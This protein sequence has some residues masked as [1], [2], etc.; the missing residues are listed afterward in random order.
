VLAPLLGRITSESALYVGLVPLGLALVAVVV[1]VRNRD[2]AARFWAWTTAGALLLFLGAPEMI[3]G[4]DQPFL[5]VRDWTFV[6][7]LVVLSLALLGGVALD[8]V[9]SGLSTRWSWGIAIALVTLTVLDLSGF[10]SRQHSRVAFPRTAELRAR[11]PAPVRPVAGFS[12]FRRKEFDIGAHAPFHKQGPAVWGIPSAY[13]NPEPFTPGTRSLV[14]LGQIYTHGS[15]YLRLPRY[16]AVLTTVPGPAFDCSAGVTCSI[17][18][19]VDTGIVVPDVGAALSALIQLPADV[20]GSVIVVEQPATGA[21]LRTVDFAIAAREAARDTGSVGTVRVST[22]RADMVELNVQ[23]HRPG[24]LYYADGYAPEWTAEVNGER[25]EILAA[26]GAFKAVRL[27]AGTHEV[28]LRYRPWRYIVTFTLRIIGI[29]GGV[30]AFLLVRTA[31]STR[32]PTAVES[33]IP[34]C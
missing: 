25:T 16:E 3:S 20:L 2:R 1:A 27:P 11:E 29:I 12:M 5:F 19:L 28:L 31:R 18:R 10:A 23:M 17:I 7:P 14:A 24:F 22:Y 8:R 30:L 6:L 26:N 15:H 9:R 21:P 34:P 33:S 32:E 13:L 4:R